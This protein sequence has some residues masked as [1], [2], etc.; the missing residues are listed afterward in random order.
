MQAK[1]LL[2]IKSELIQ[3]MQQLRLSI[4]EASARMS[5]TYHEDHHIV[6]RLKSYYPALNKQEEYV[7]LLDSLIMEKNYEGIE[8]LSAKIKAIADMIKSD[9]KSLL[10]SLQ[11]GE[12]EF[13]EGVIWN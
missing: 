2:E 3:S 1:N 12:E 5:Q 8:L 6:Q 9:A 7:N 11:T 10:W 4:D 13:P